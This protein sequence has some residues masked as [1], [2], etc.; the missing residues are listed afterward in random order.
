MRKMRKIMCCFLGFIILLILT[1]LGFLTGQ[2]KTREE[3]RNYAARQLRGEVLA[4]LV[5]TAGRLGNDAVDAAAIK[6]IGESFIVLDAKRQS[7]RNIY[8]SERLGSLSEGQSV[9]FEL[10]TKLGEFVDRR[11][12]LSSGF[13][14]QLKKICDESIPHFDGEMRSVSDFEYELNALETK[15]KALIQ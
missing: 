9:W 5:T 4:V 10:G 12:D 15:L 7:L 13:S 2:R 6:L 8:G 11:E 1:F 14:S 3:Y